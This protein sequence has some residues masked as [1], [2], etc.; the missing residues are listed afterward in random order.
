MQL[1]SLYI[2]E[3]IQKRE[4]NQQYVLLFLVLLLFSFPK[5]VKSGTVLSALTVGIN[6]NWYV[7][8]RSS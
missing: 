1:P 5:N 6:E 3:Q 4:L 2:K 7:P 8:S